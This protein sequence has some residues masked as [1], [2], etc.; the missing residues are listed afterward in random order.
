MTIENLSEAAEMVDAIKIRRGAKATITN[1]LVIGTGAVDDL[2][3]LTDSKGDAQGTTVISVTNELTSTLQAMKYTE[4]VRYRSR[5]QIPELLPQTSIGQ[6]IS[7]DSIGE[8][9]AKRILFA[10]TCNWIQVRAN[11]FIAAQ[12]VLL[13]IVQHDNY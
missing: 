6:D 7:S 8:L 2:V 3:D 4:Q 1:A 10:R 12:P 9:R 13:L 11:C 5:W